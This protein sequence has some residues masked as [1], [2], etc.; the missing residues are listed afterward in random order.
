MTP[1]PGWQAQADQ[2]YAQ[3]A[4]WIGELGDDYVEELAENGRA[5]ARFYVTGLALADELTRDHLAVALTLTVE[6]LND[7]RHHPPQQGPDAMTAFF[8]ERWDA[9]RVDDATQVPTP[10]GD[11]CLYCTEPIEADDRGVLMPYV[12]R[13][14]DGVVV[15]GVAPVHMECDL[16]MGIGTAEHLR[17]DCACS[18]PDVVHED[19]KTFRQEARE[20]LAAVNVDRVLR[21]R[22]PL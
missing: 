16:R 7:L 1:S 8:G 18:K 6:Q 2:M 20:T 3:C 22:G 17:G 12:D 9:P 4:E 15:G 13:V 10:V 19:T 11:P 14:E 5:A 21:G